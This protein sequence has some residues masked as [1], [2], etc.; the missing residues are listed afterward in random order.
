MMK[1]IDVSSYQGLPDWSQVAKAGIR[2]AIL[3]ITELYGTDTS[4][5]HNYKGCKNNGIQVGVYKLSYARTE[6]QAIKEAEDVLAVLNGRGLDFPVV[7]DVEWE[8]QMN[9]GR[10]ALTNIINAFLGRIK[11]AGYKTAI[12]SN[13]NWCNNYFFPDKVETQDFWLAS[14]PNQNYDN[15]TPVA[16]LKPSRANMGWQYSWQGKVPGIS[17]NVDMDEFYKEYG[18]ATK[19]ETPD[20]VEAATVWME[21]HAADPANG[22]DQRF[23]WGEKGDWDCSSAVH[24]AWQ[25]A[26]V[27]IK[28]YAFSHDGVAYTGNMPRTLQACGFENVTAEVNLATGAGLQ[29]GDILLNVQNHVAMYCGNGKEVEA[30]INEFGGITGG[31]PGDQTGREFLVKNYA[32]YPWNQ[33]WRFR[34]AVTQKEVATAAGAPN[35]TPKW[36]GAVTADRLNVR[37]WAGTEYPKIKSWPELAQGNLVDVCDTVKD[38]EGDFWYYVRISARYYGFVH[39]DYIEKR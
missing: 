35:K 27:P 5:E 13:T 22:Y 8:Q 3:R 23:R 20:P 18:T 32:N 9:L 31:T 19:D 14:V 38:K 6:A 12:Y 36:V 15:G 16:Y 26:G 1:G 10:Q 7:Y 4:F 30:S 33:V 34:K 17:G 25:D 28:D 37:S 11:K 24:Q 21:N 39:S 2:V 29:R